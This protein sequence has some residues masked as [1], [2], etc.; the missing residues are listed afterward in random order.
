MRSN[1]KLSA[2][3]MCL[4][5][6][7]CMET[8]HQ[9]TESESSK[10]PLASDDFDPNARK[11]DG[12]G[13]TGQIYLSVTVENLM[14]SHDGN[15]LYTNGKDGVS[16]QFQAPDG[17]LSFTMSPPRKNVVGRKLTFPTNGT[18]Y[19]IELNGYPSYLVNVLTSDVSPVQ[20]KIQ[21]LVVGE[22]QE[23]S[24]RVWG[25]N[26]SG[27]GF[28]LLYS[29]G[30]GLGYINDKV[31]VTCT[32]IGTWTVESKTVE[33]KTE[34]QATLTGPDNYPSLGEYSVPFKLTLNKIN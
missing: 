17:I 16:A 9:L 27:I 4:A 26:S 8:G 5:L 10:I 34:A 29:L 14:I 32:A 31:L 18:G 24:M 6:A 30:S 11:G 22:S 20:K 19:A 23:M 7:G 12:G 1:L 13:T 28:R 15:A 3:L 2:I 33:S 21:D 25:S